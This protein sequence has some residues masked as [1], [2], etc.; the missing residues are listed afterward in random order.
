M[1]QQEYIEALDKAWGFNGFL[2]TLRDGKFDK[3]LYDELYHTLKEIDIQDD[4]QI[5]RE[6]I[7]LLWFIPIFMYRQKEYIP[8]VPSKEYDALRENL[9]EELARIL[10]Y[11]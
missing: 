11:P 10:I 3:K 9:E 2:G 4:E 8:D 1:K 5:V 6:L 7:Q